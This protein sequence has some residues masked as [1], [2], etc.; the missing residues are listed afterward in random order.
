MFEFVGAITSGFGIL[1]ILNGPQQTT[2]RGDG[3]FVI[4]PKSS[5]IG[6]GKLSF[7]KSFGFIRTASPGWNGSGM[8]AQEPEVRYIRFF[9]GVH[10]Q[11]DFL[12][13][14]PAGSRR[15]PGLMACVQLKPSG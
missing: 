3:I 1:G 12:D 7:K 15:D 9:F 2:S 8:D 10:G 4:K 13:P 5:E 6:H 14:K 11:Q